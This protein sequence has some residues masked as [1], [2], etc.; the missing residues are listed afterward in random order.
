[1]QPEKPEIAMRYAELLV[2]ILRDTAVSLGFGPTVLQRDEVSVVRR[3]DS[4]GMSFITEDLPTLGKA[5]DK[6]LAQDTIIVVP[7][8]FK[9]TRYGSIKIPVFLGTLWKLVFRPDG[10]IKENDEDCAD[11]R[12]YRRLGVYPDNPPSIVQVTAVRA[13]RQIC[14][15]GYKL[16]YPFDRG[17]QL[18]KIMDFKSIDHSLPECGEQVD[19]SYRTRMAIENANALVAFT[20]R[21]LNPE[22]IVPRHGPGAVATGEKPWEKFRFQRFY[23]KLD[24]IFNYSEYFYFNMG[25]LCD[26][27]DSLMAMGDIPEATSKIVLVPKDSR[28]PRL[29]SMEPLELQWIQQGLAREIIKF[30]ENSRSITA[31]YVNFTDQDVN[32][33]LALDASAR[34]GDYSE[35]ITLDLKDASDRVSLWLVKKLFPDHLYACLCACRSGAIL[36]R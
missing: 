9:A 24:R 31:G 1:M 10:K 16:E 29:I 22:R 34:R 2:R 18:M 4:E 28:G 15:L 23:P 21:G 6:A 36:E 14:Y 26:E 32:R 33:D 13:I 27:L 20:L 19:L 8:C 25:H 3:V 5:F 12:A 35:F 11:K 30:I 7:P 17:D